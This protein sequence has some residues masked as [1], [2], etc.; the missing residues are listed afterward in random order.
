[1]LHIKGQRLKV[2]EKR[3]LKVFEPMRYEIKGDW[4]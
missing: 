4:S 2:C 3:V 1:V